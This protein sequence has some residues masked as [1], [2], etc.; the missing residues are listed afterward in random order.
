MVSGPLE[1]ELAAAANHPMLVLRPAL[2]SSL[3]A[4]Q[5]LLKKNKKIKAAEPALISGFYNTC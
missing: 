3:R 5:I 4:I 2:R 1:L